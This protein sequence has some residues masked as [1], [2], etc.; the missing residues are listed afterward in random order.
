[1]ENTVSRRG[2]VAGAAFGSAVLGTI[3]LTSA[4]HADE[5]DEAPAT[6]TASNA[7][8]TE[9]WLGEAPEI[10]ADEI[11]NTLET[12]TLI[13]G[14]GCSGLVAGMAAAER[15]MDFILCESLPTYGGSHNDIGAMGS[16]FPGG[17][18][19]RGRQGPLA[20]R[21]GALRLVQERPDRGPRVDRL[22]G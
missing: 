18:R 11:V 5:T 21:V 22:L 19:P 4:A 15:G 16:R 20:Q 8:S 9:G 10:S 6:E 17:G 2:F 1:M 14:A 7:E 13:V 3:A 12:E